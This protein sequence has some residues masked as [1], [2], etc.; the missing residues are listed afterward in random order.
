MQNSKLGLLKDI[1]I[2]TDSS[3]IARVEFMSSQKLEKRL[4]QILVGLNLFVLSLGGGFIYRNSHLL[5]I[6]D[7]RSLVQQRA[8]IL[9]MIYS[10]DPIST[11]LDQEVGQFIWLKVNFEVFDEE[12]LNELR[13]VEGLVKDTLVGILNEKAFD[14]LESIQGKLVFK[15]QIILRVNNL[16]SHGLIQNIYFSEFAVQ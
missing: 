6:L 1:F 2:F 14:E 16:L 15:D 10:M 8:D 9:P 3:Y 4:I 11:N 5:H 13:Q 12:S 7:L